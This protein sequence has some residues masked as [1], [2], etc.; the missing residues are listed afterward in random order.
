MH[1]QCE[2][3][4]TLSMA[5]KNF[6]TLFSVCPSASY[7]T[8]LRAAHLLLRTLVT[9]SVLIILLQPVFAAV[10]QRISLTCDSSGT[11]VRA[12]YWW[13]GLSSAVTLMIFY[14]NTVIVGLVFKQADVSTGDKACLVSNRKKDTSFALAYVFFW[15]LVPLY[16]LSVASW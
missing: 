16:L 6:A 9:L 1:A 7:P 12:F 4:Y 10:C 8:T 15:F 3:P 14:L 13:W 11:F 5:Q 2:K